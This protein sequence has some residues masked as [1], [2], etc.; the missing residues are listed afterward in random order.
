MRAA[1]SVYFLLVLKRR[2][3]DE[4]IGVTS[5]I[6]E[7]RARHRV[8]GEDEPL[9]VAQIEDE[10]VRHA[11][12]IDVNG[13]EL[14]EARER[15]REFRFAG[16]QLDDEPIALLIGDGGY[17]AYVERN[18]INT[19]VLLEVE[20]VALVECERLSHVSVAHEHERLV[21]VAVSLERLDSSFDDRV[22]AGHVIKMRV[23]HEN[24]LH[25]EHQLVYA[26]RADE[27]A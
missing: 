2:L 20:K 7:Q 21:R 3:V 10:A 13:G 23:R 22:E 14:A 16:E 5:H 17:V 18:V 6:G 11:R 27:N 26:L 1:I 19:K 9:A 25:V 24:R 8:A 12:M 15:V 4:K